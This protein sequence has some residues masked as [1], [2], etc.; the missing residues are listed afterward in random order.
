MPE[1]L[2][3]IHKP[4]VFVLMPLKNKGD[5]AFH[6]EKDIKCLK[7]LFINQVIGWMMLGFE[8]WSDPGYKVMMLLIV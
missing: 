4:K 8:Q 6:Y 5:L 2:P 3:L 1:L 7:S